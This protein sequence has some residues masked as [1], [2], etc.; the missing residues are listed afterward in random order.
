MSRS[1]GYCFTLNNYTDKE[2]HEL[3]QLFA[4]GGFKYI[5][6]GKEVASS[7]TP[8]LQGY[9]YMPN[10]ITSKGFKKKLGNSR[11][12]V[13]GAKGTAEE[14]RVYCSKDGDFLEFGDMPFSQSRK[15]EKGGVV[16][17]ERWEEARQLAKEGNFDDIPA[18]ILMRCYGTCQKLFHENNLKK[19]LADNGAMANLWI[20]GPTGCGKSKSVRER[21]PEEEIY[22]KPLNKW[23]DG[24]SGEPVVLIEDIDPSHEKWIGYFLKIWSDHYKFRA[25]VKGTSIMMR[26][27]TVVVTS[28]YP[29]NK[30]FQDE[31]TVLA[32]ERRFRTEH[33]L[34]EINCVCPACM[35]VRLN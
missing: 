24:Y 27:K 17:Q 12:H 34:P 22:L 2:H 20:W 32:L 16:Q 10:A 5:I 31:Q 1:R 15:G 33:L 21:F 28:Q 13:E 19:Q 30:I 11:V 18:D 35:R 26:P 25:E 9:A 7:G 3:C 29:I 8:H 23:F 6:F 4:G 14:N